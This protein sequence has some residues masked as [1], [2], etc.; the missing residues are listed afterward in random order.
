MTWQELRNLYPD[1]WLLV[2]ALNAATQNGYRIVS[3]LRLVSD[4]DNHWDQAWEQ[5]KALH[6]MDSY[7]EY[8]ILHTSRES[9]DIQVIDAFG[10]IMS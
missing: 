9:L 1:R 4:F 2:E 10:R 8:Y 7:R 6:R 3:D 5:Y